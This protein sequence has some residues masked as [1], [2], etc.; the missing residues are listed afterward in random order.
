MNTPSALGLAAVT[1][2]VGLG[3]GWFVARPVGPALAPTA[4]VVVA[5]APAAAAS[6]PS[7]APSTPDGALAACEAQLATAT[8]FLEALRIATAGE[9]VAFPDD[10][11]DAYTPE[12]FEANVQQAVT[13]CGLTASATVVDCSEY[14]CMVATDGPSL[15]TCD[16]WNERYP[17][18]VVSRA[19]D[20]VQT[21]EGPVRYEVLGEL[22]PG[23]TG[24]ENQGKRV[25]ER[26]EAVRSEMMAELGGFEPS[27]AEKKQQ[28]LD[29][30]RGVVADQPDNDSARRMLERME[31]SQ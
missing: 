27:E 12:G 19:T 13:Q 30:W 1:F 17:Q 25:R 28:Q 9:P 26:F 4:P 29:F 8:Q 2:L 16:W 23:R 5:Q 24:D 14:P 21:D 22:A 10:V 15:K 31:A 11:P 20:S 7:P 3:S 6:A 18:Q